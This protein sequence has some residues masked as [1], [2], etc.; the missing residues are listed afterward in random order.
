MLKTI[1]R[2]ITDHIIYM[3]HDDHTDRPILASISGANLT[4]GIDAGNSSVH[5]NLFLQELAKHNEKKID[6]LVLTHWHWDHVFGCSRMNLPIISHV[7]TQEQL[8]KL[9]GLAWT[10]EALDERVKA[11]SEIPFC[12]EMIKKE[13]PTHRDIRIETPSIVFEQKLELDLGGVNCL[14]E[15]VGGDH[16]SDSCIVYVKE[17]KVLFLGDCL[18]PDYYNGDWK[19]TTQNVLVLLDRLQTYD[20]DHYIISHRDPLTKAEFQQEA[21]FYRKISTLLGQHGNDHSAICAGLSHFIGRALIEEE[22]FIVDWFVN[23]FKMNQPN[24]N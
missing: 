11:G 8:V 24:D 21:D 16:S 3:P 1:L 20:A 23:G 6:F 10:D 7:G 12:A 5:A 15:H 9:Q 14:I 13:F 22:L 2:R 4:L 19:Y 18:Y 17:D